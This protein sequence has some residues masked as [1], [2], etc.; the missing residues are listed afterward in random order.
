MADL[1]HIEKYL[2]GELT[3]QEMSEFEDVMRGDAEAQEQVAQHKQ[4]LRG[5]E[6]GFNKELKELLIEEESKIQDT[7]VQKPSRI[8]SLYPLMGLAVAVALLIITFFTLRDDSLNPEELYA[9]YYKVYPNVES[10]VSRSESSEMNPF[11]AYEAGDYTTAMA[12]FTEMHTS[13]PENPALLFYS[14]MCQL[15]LGQPKSA[16]ELFHE[17]VNMQ[18]KKYTRPA[19]W[20]QSLAYLK[21]G[22][23]KNAKNLL[24]QLLREDDVYATKANEILNVL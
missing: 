23:I 13:D 12:N 9:Q 10:P 17:V 7:P 15:E 18:S 14:G 16:V 11:A 22:S 5:L 6:I 3:E 4:L 24:E 21:S 19:M 20:Y 1:D 8:K 2:K